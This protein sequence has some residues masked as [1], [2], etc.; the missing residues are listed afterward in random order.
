MKPAVRMYR[1]LLRLYPADW[2]ALFAPEILDAFEK[3]A[4]ERRAQ[5][6]AAFARFTLVELTGLLAEAAAAWIAKFTSKKYM[7]GFWIPSTMRRPGQSR[8]DWC[9]PG[10]R[11]LSEVLEEQRR[12][13][14]YLRQMVNAISERDF[15]RARF[16]SEEDLTIRNR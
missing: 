2:R 13:D 7:R 5:G 9:P 1:I 11:V 4:R 8:E 15:K 16:Y 12:A 14:F 6:R 3:S 10:A